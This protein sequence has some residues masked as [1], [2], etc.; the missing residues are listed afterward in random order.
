MQADDLAPWHLAIIN[1]VT[2]PQQ[3]KLLIHLCRRGRTS[4]TE[5]ERACRVRSATKRMSELGR[6]KGLPVIAIPGTELDADGEPFRTKFY[7]V[8]GSM[9][10]RDLFDSD[11]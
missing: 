2:A 11:E 7:E 5:L 3:R 8:R 1:A 4:R 10:Q 9:P 6:D